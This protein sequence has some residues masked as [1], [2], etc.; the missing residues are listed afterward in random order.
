[1]VAHL[2]VILAAVGDDLD[3][4]VGAIDLVSAEERRTLL[5]EWNDTARHLPDA[6]LPELLA[7]Q[8]ARTPAARPSGPRS[9]PR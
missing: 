8:V 9:T 6:T 7:A 5:V 2:Q 4:P 1:M 3:R